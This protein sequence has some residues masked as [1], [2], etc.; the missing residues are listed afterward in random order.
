VS[1]DTDPALRA[2]LEARLA[3]R[4]RDSNLDLN[5]LRRRVVFERLLA[6]LD[7][8]DPGAWVLKGGMALELRWWG[9]AR[10]TRDLD[11]AV[12][13]GADTADGVRTGMAN[14]LAGDVGGD[15]FEF[16]VGHARPLRDD[17]AG[18][19]GWRLPVDARLAGRSFA[20]VTVDVVVRPDEISRTERLALPG[21]LA[22]AGVP[23][24][25]AEVVDRS[26]HIAEKLH[27][28][29]R[30]YAAGASTRVRDLVDVVL[31]ID[32]GVRPDPQTARVVR[33][34]FEARDTHPLPTTVGDPPADWSDRYAELARDL[35]L[36]AH[37]IDQA[38]ATLRDFWTRLRTED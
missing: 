12:R 16:V 3:N 27:A 29:T 2:A 33:E 35:D 23:A 26:Q 24:G 25:E 34:V 8:T 6:R 18:R 22:F 38:M 10:A 36:S 19:P 5:R 21:S 15:R 17:E 14:A 13:D 9:R 28:L 7:D 32:D 4:A 37:D 30:T 31:L 11:L 1:Y 20:S